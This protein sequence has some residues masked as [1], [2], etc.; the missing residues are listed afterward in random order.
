MHRE[1]SPHKIRGGDVSIL[2]KE[3]GDAEFC[4]RAVGHS[5]IATTQ[6]YIT[7]GGEEKKRAAEIMSFI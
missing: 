3:T 6:R 2:Y 4:R 5:N 1:L 7:T